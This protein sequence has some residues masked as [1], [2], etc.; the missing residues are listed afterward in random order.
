MILLDSTNISD[1]I[2]TGKDLIYILT[3]VVSGLL[4]WFKMQSDKDKHASRIQSLEN[5]LIHIEDLHKEKLADIRKEL[6]EKEVVLHR[7]LDKTQ[8]DMRSHANK[9][10]LEFKNLSEKMGGMATDISEMKGMLKTLVD[11]RH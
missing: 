11:K 2:F 3:F 1:L 5:S 9:T 7:R 10:D 4:A 6:T 8:E